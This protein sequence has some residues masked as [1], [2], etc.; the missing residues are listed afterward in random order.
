M[1]LG[2]DEVLTLKTYDTHIEDLYLLCSDGLT[3][4]VGDDEIKS[5]LIDA[6][7]DMQ[8]AAKR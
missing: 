1:R 8:L 7:G 2:H 4:L 6:C 5:T 3:D